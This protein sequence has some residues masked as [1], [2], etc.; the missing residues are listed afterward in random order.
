MRS[1]LRAHPDLAE[2]QTS[3]GVLKFWLEWDW[4]GAEA[5]LRRAIAVDGHYAYPFRMLGHVLSQTG[6]HPAARIALQ[7]ARELDPLYAM[8]HAL[9]AQ[10]AFQARDF[11][12]ALEHARHSLDVDPNFWPGYHQLAQVQ[13]Q[14]GE[15][16]AALTAA[17]TASR[18]S[19]GNSKAVSL[20]RISWPHR[21]WA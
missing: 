18:L 17:D 3:S 15:M 5:A 11:D 12:A 9:S 7:R 8:H 6:R 13:E 10:L 4:P 2:A 20:R 16:D 19:G 1:A 14:R 21:V